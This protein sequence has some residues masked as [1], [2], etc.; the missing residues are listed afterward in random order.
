MRCRVALL[1]AGLL[2][3]APLASVAPGARAAA[4][5]L[6]TY[7]NVGQWSQGFQG[8]VTLTNTGDKI[9][10]WTLAFTFADGAQK[11]T[12][13]WS[14]TFTQYGAA[15]T[16]TNAAWNGSLATRA[17]TNF[18]FIGTYGSANPW[19]ATFMVNGVTCDTTPATGTTSATT[20]AGPGTAGTA[21]PARP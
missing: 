6:V 11:V 1:T 14:S 18:G 13:G 12:Q 10:G 17:S 20:T 4:G 19:P 7:R 8:D 2:A 3:L 21:P 15:V 5:C 9:T 16:F